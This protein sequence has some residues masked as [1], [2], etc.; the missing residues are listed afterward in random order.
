VAAAEDEMAHAGEA[1]YQ[2]TNDDFE[3]SLQRLQDIFQ[4]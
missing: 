2:I 3:V 4:H 1:H